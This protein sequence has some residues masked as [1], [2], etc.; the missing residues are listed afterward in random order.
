MICTFGSVTFCLLPYLSYSILPTLHFPFHLIKQHYRREKLPFKFR[1]G[2]RFL[3]LFLR[4][5]VFFTV[6]FLQLINFFSIFLLS[7]W[8][9]YHQGKSFQ[10]CCYDLSLSWFYTFIMFSFLCFYCHLTPFLFATFSSQYC[11]RCTRGCHVS[12]LV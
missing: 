3:W 11:P 12:T 6:F 1:F 8:K 9:L 10:K 4:H 7:Q 5:C 2:P